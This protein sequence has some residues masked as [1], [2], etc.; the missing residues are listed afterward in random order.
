MG[1]GKK[2]KNMDKG[3]NKGSHHG[4]GKNM[5]KGMNKGSHHGN[6]K[7]MDKG[8]NK[9]SQHGQGHEQGLAPAAILQARQ[10]GLQNHLN[11]MH[12]LHEELGLPPD[13]EVMHDLDALR[14]EL[15]LPPHDE[16]VLPLQYTEDEDEEEAE[17]E[18][19]GQQAEEDWQG[20]NEEEDQGL[21]LHLPVVPRGTVRTAILRGKGKVAPR[22]T[23]GK[24]KGKVGAAI[25]KGKGKEKGKH[26]SS[27]PQSASSQ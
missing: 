19:Q 5:D 14:E 3:M 7:N 17:E 21:L 25:L 2:G 27:S 1:K 10:E 22:G 12:G 18:D 24:G 6:G 16:V 4:K 26:A 8:M 20:Q 11:F 23:V 9:G 13:Y 15:G